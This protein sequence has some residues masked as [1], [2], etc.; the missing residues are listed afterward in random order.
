LSHRGEPLLGAVFDVY[1][2]H[3]RVG[4]P[5]GTAPFAPCSSGA[6]RRQGPKP[7]ST[8]RALRRLRVSRCHRVL[9]RKVHASAGLPGWLQ[10]LTMRDPQEPA[11]L[12][13]EAA[14]TAQR[15]GLPGSGASSN[16]EH[17][18]HRPVFRPA[19]EDGDSSP[20]ARAPVEATR[21]SRQA[22]AGLSQEP[23]VQA[24]A[25][26]G[27][28]RK[29]L[30]SEGHGPGSALRTTGRR[31]LDG[32]APAPRPAPMTGRRCRQI[33]TGERSGGIRSR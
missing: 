12:D 31:S 2:P 14:L 13:S 8:G 7:R 22:C 28:R 26:S 33:R 25:T 16:A 20:E 32:S 21:V 18:G 17:P 27:T 1:K 11:P 6:N 19:R 9:R 15:P 4:G 29:D 24:N 5:T 10:D 23:V 30:G 3:E